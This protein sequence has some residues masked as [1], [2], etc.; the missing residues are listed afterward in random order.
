MEAVNELISDVV[1]SELTSVTQ[2]AQLVHQK[3][4]GNPFFTIAFL[5]KLYQTGMLVSPQNITLHIFHSFRHVLNYTMGQQHFN[6]E[7]YKWRWNLSEIESL[8]FTD[9]VV[10]FMVQDLGRLAESTSKLLQ[11]G[12]L[13]GS[14]FD[15]RDVAHV[16]SISAGEGMSVEQAESDLWEALHEGII[17][18]YNLLLVSFNMVVCQ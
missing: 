14:K 18:I 11:L 16:G 12:A 9:N 3:T 6:Y 13:F 2:L 8:S 17:Y 7:E 5:T 15:L 10:E 4:H 1:H